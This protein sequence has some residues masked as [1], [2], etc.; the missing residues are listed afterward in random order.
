M[1][2]F[3]G[4][5]RLTSAAMP[6]CHGQRQVSWPELH[7]RVQRRFPE[8]AFRSVGGR[9]ALSADHRVLV[10]RL[11]RLPLVV[12]VNLAPENERERIVDAGAVDP[13]GK[14]TVEPVGLFRQ[15]SKS[16][17]QAIGS[18]VAR[19]ESAFDGDDEI[20]EAHAGGADGTQ[21]AVAIRAF[22]SQ[23][24]DGVAEIVEVAKP[25]LLHLG[26]QHFDLRRIGRGSFSRPS[27]KRRRC[28]YEEQ[29]V[30]HSQFASRLNSASTVHFQTGP[31]T[32]L[33]GRLSRRQ[34]PMSKQALV[35][36]Q[37]RSAV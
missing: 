26:Q 22:A 8:R 21:V 2:F 27:D 33:P 4:P 7:H 17:L 29:P 9:H 16:R 34:R 12:K 25:R 32:I 35:L 10:N 13:M 37:P 14:S 19:H 28:H 1:V 36:P 24:G 3:S 30:V 23:A 5:S 18:P 31:P 6:D 11:L 15:E 20:E